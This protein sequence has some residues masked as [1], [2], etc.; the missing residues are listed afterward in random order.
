MEDEKTDKSA[1]T[2][3][4][5]QQE[6]EAQ[7]VDNERIESSIAES[8]AQDPTRNEIIM[9][10]ILGRE[11]LIKALKRVKKNKGSPGIDGMKVDQLPRYLKENWLEIRT[12]LLEGNYKPQPIKRV[13][14]PKPGGGVR[15]LGIPTAMDRFI[16][17]AVMQVLEKQWDA[18]FSEYSYG[19]RPNRS[20]HQAVAQAQRYIAEGYNIVVDIDLE[21]FFD[22]VNHDILMGRI[23]KRVKDKPV[24]KLIRSFLNAGV[25]QQ[26]LVSATEEGMPQGSPLSPLMS[27]LLLDELD[28]ELEKRGHRFVRYADDSNIYVKSQ[29]AGQRVMESVTRF[30]EQKLK[31]YVNKQ[32][33]AVGKPRERK[34]LGFSFLGKQAKRIIASKTLERFKDK[35]RQITGR[36]RGVSLQ[37][38][39]EEL[40]T[41]LRGWQGYFGFC[42]TPSVMQKLNS[43]IRRR[44]RC[45]ILRHWKNGKYKQ[46][47][48]RGLEHSLAAKISSSGKGLWRISKSL[49]LSLALPVLY[50]TLIGIPLLTSQTLV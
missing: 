17:Q 39:I 26:G 6:G 35:I 23:A 50:F 37:Q 33:S 45:L 3:L 7:K 16:Q 12:Q 11:N 43:W 44:L 4:Y 49:A 5:Y 41:Y 8:K 13:E 19:F 22:K 14:I 31:L 40:R 28:K 9:E 46:L 32:K 27:N 25:M 18:T 24:L 36:N 42:Q 2:E 30:L 15:K 21:K 38:V 29:R 20:A 34:F 47:S 10:E 48:K 1:Y